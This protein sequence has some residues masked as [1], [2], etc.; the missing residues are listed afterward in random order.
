MCNQM[1]IQIIA[2]IE[3]VLA[4]RTPCQVYRG[5][6]AWNSFSFESAKMGVGGSMA[7]EVF[8]SFEAFGARVAGERSRTRF[9][10][11]D[12]GADG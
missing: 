9:G 1:W 7:G 3:F 2:P 10:S 11:E 5:L 8:R 12:K 4:K 6:K